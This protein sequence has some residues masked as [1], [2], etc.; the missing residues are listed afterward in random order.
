M[1]SMPLLRTVLQD[2]AITR[3]L[4]DEEA[5]ILVEWLVEWAELLA[6][7][8]ETEDAAWKGVRFLCRR[9]R[10]LGKFV[11]L[12]CNDAL[13]GAAVQLAAAERFHWPLPVDDEDPADLMQ[14]ILKWEDRELAL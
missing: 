6:E 12:W 3:G 11:Y 2:E 10:G 7:E 13:R 14:R 5:R 1:L 9:A 8:S 4:G